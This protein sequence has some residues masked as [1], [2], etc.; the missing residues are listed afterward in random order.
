MK[1]DRLSLG[2]TVSSS[3]VSRPAVT[4]RIPWRDRPYGFGHGGTASAEP[5]GRT[6][7]Q[8]SGQPGEVPVD[9]RARRDES[10]VSSVFAREPRRFSPPSRLAG[11]ALGGGVAAGG[12]RNG[13]A[14][15]CF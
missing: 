5:P 6:T 11:A 12:R 9:G 13:R 14:R 10:T 7:W 2:R 4:I 1:Q 15:F 3:P 8:T